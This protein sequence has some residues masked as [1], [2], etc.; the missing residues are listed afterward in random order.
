MDSTRNAGS[1]SR[2]IAIEANAPITARAM[3]DARMSRYAF[4]FMP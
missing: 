4:V 2:A 1:L 3:T